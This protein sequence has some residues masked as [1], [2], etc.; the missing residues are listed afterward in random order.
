MYIPHPARQGE[1]V[2]FICWLKYHVSQWMERRAM[3]WERDALN[4][5]WREDDDG[6]PF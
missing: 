3:I 6:I 4:P 5:K 1:S 2:S